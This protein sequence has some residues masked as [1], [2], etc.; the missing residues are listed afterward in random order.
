MSFRFFAS[1]LALSL[2]ALTFAQTIT[3]TPKAANGAKNILNLERCKAEDDPDIDLYDVTIDFTSSGILLGS[4]FT[5]KLGEDCTTDTNCFIPFKDEVLT[6]TITKKTIT[7]KPSE[8]LELV[9]QTSCEGDS[10]NG[11]IKELSLF[12]EVTDATGATTKKNTS[13]DDDSSD[14][15]FIDTEIPSAPLEPKASGGENVLN[16]SWKTNDDNDNGA[17]PLEEE[18]NFRIECRLTGSTDEF[19]ECGG[20]SGDA[21]VAGTFKD[22]VD[23]VGGSILDNGESIDLQIVTIDEAGNPSEPTAIFTGTPQD[24]LDFGENFNG[25][26]Q[27]GC[28]VGHGEGQL[29]WVGF[30]IVVILLLRK[31]KNNEAQI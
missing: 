6:D 9:G 2:P 17:I 12:V 10:N 18:F 5:I 11:F 4:K 3:I 7:Q 16:V 23:A 31:N 15:T 29:L 26:E 13:N 20:S 21:G 30:L 8:L 14:N 22:T 27:G 24:V 1:F 28:A 25:A 19:T